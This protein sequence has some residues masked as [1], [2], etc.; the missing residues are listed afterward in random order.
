MMN[1][2]IP[3]DLLDLKAR[4]DQ[5]RATRKYIRQPIPEELL[6]AVREISDRHPRSLV[7]RLLKIE[8][9]HL[10]QPKVNAPAKTASPTRRSASFFQLPA[11]TL[12]SEPLSTALSA[13]PCRLQIERPDG[14][15]LT[16]T[17]PVLD[18]ASTRELCADFLRGDR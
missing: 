3:A 9:R 14:S 8:L 1:A 2:T 13:A 18:F 6:Q 15:R 10:R 7:R 12:L 11:D 17:L 4:F 16:L 5:W